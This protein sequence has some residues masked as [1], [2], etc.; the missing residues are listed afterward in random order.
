MKHLSLKLKAMILFLSGIALL[1]I[2][3]LAVTIYESKSL[4]KEQIK[5]EKELILEMNKKELKAYTQMAE[6]SIVH[7]YQRSL[8]P[9]LD[10]SQKDRKSVV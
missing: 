4:I 2:T 3:S 8:D 6:T 5:D 1:T 10:A 9:S 7:L